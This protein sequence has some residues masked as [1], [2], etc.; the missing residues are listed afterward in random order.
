MNFIKLRMHDSNQWESILSHIFGKNIVIHDTNIGKNKFYSKTY[1]QFKNNYLIPKKYL[2][3]HLIN[4][5]QFKIY[6]S[7]EEQNNYIKYWND[8]SQQQI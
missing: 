8:K 1:D 5:K 6:N 2:D 7:I 4:D 3:E